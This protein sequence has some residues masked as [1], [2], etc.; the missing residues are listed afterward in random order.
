MCPF[1]CARKAGSKLGPHR[2]PAPLLGFLSGSP[3]R[4]MGASGRGAGLTSGFEKAGACGWGSS[5]GL[6]GG[7]WLDRPWASPPPRPRSLSPARGRVTTFPFP[8]LLDLL[9]LTRPTSLSPALEMSQRAGCAARQVSR[10]PGRS[11]LRAVSLLCSPRTALWRLHQPRP[12][13]GILQSIRGSLADASRMSPG[14]GEVG[15]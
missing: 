10:V 6:V 3:G 14:A 11:L 9:H 12:A 8:G 2:D 13:P 1:V 15:F 7:E 5:A 4:G